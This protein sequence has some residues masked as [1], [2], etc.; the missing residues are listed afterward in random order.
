VHIDVVATDI[1]RVAF[2]LNHLAAATIVY[3]IVAVTMSTADPLD[4]STIIIM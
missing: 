2:T 4:V 1:T 3:F